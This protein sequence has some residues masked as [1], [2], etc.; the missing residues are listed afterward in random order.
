M[1]KP[2]SSVDILWCR[3]HWHLKNV[4]FREASIF[5][6][7]WLEEIVTCLNPILQQL[8]ASFSKANSA[9][10]SQSSFFDIVKPQVS[11]QTIWKLDLPKLVGPFFRKQECQPGFDKHC[12]LLLINRQDRLGNVLRNALVTSKEF[13]KVFVFINQEILSTIAQYVRRAST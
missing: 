12:F 6:I 9:A 4:T 7:L 2:K 8:K 1:G 10:S 3:K 13:Q 5:W 11:Q